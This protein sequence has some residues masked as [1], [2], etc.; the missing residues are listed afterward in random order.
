M[1]A[2]A[3]PRPASATCTQ[4]SCMVSELRLTLQERLQVRPPD[5]KYNEQGLGLRVR[6]ALGN[7]LGSP[8]AGLRHAEGH[9]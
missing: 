7:W 3:E 9:S 4:H 5:G 8:G 1:P 6:Q 2:L